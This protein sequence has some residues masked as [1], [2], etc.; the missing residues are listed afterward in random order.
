M[1]YGTFVEIDG[2]PA[3]RFER[4]LAHPIER[5][6]E[7]VTDP[8]QLAGWFP[9]RVERDGDELRFAFEG[10]REASMHGKVL[11]EDPPRVF[12]FR[13][14]D[15]ELRF[16]LRPDGDGCVLVL[17]NV[18]DGT[19]PAS[20]VAAGWHV[21]LGELEKLLAGGPSSMPGTEPTPEHER[22]QAEYARRGAPA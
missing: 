21:C 4:R 9:A 20:S 8:A 19:Y 10:E 1:T 14:E 22:L 17:T 13:W 15:D 16:E 2:R 12:A 6:W 3:V 5:V 18:L 11:E 7:A